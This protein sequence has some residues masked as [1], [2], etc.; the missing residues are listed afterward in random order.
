MKTAV[1]FYEQLFEHEDSKKA[2][3]M[4]CKWLAKNVISKV[5]VS[6][7]QYKITKENGTSLP[8]FKLELFAMLDDKEERKSFCERCR[9]FHKLFYIN[10][11]FNCNKCNMMAFQENMKS[12]LMV[13]K[14]YRKDI[15][16]RNLEDEEDGM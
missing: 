10:Q 9:E 11:Q 7:S 5:E 2:Y 3:L 16:K 15:M 6:D 13:K 14:A 12:K 1:K 8:T 4:A